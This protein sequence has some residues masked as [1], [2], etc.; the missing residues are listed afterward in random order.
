MNPEGWN[1]RSVA[2]ILRGTRRRRGFPVTGPTGGNSFGAA[3][4]TRICPPLVSDV[5]MYSLPREVPTNGVSIY[6]GGVDIPQFGP[7]SVAQTETDRS[8][9]PRRVAEIQLRPWLTL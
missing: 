7:R 6:P 9:N 8:E 5:K 1:S 4:G 2:S 3:A